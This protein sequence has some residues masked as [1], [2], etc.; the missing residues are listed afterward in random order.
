MNLVIIIPCFNEEK[1]LPDVLK[2]IPKK[3][4][5][6]KKI[7]TVVINDGSTDKTLAVAKKMGVKHFVIH[8]QNEGLANSFA[9]G[10]DKALSLGADIIVN[11]DGDNQY[12]Q[13]DIPRLIKPII[14]KKAD[15]V[16]A[17]RQIDKIKHFSLGKKILQK[18]GS[19]VVR[20]FSGT[21]VPDATSGFR[22]YSREA[23]LHL[24]IFTE[25]SHT[26]ETIIQAGKKKLHI[27]SVK[28]KTRPKSRDSRL[29]K[30]LWSYIKQSVATIL[31]L[32]AI[33]EP[34]K[35][36]GYISFLIS[37]PGI[38]LILRFI[39]LYIRG[40]AGGHIQSL[41]FGS[42]FIFIGV[43]IGLLGVIA[44]LIA[45]NRKKYENILYRMKKIEYKK[46]NVF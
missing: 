5:G 36:F 22:A 15:I 21:K 18:L 33:Y 7:E 29:I 28:V 24:N 40:D 32:F 37:L 45:I 12:P 17:D 42:L 20:V 4:P 26:I 8:K 6:I 41:I 3:I 2:T 19:A 46:R 23:A 34:L 38:I 10:L 11:T 9:D 39:Y 25:Y 31:R 27:E 44:D 13:E 30:N 16:I 14:D 1:T 43:Q 35:V